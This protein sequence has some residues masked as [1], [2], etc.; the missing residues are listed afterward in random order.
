MIFRRYSTRAYTEAREKVG[1]VNADLQE[2]VAGLR[3]SQA[4]GRQEVNA[5]G[6]AARSEDYR[7]SRM[8]AQ[9]AISIYFPFVALLSEL[10]AAVVLGSAR[11]VVAGALTV[12]T[13]LAFILYLDYF[14][15][16]IQ[17]LSQIFDA[18]QQA[19]VGLRRIG[20]L[21]DTPTSTPAADHPV[22]VRPLSGEVVADGVGFCYSHGRRRRG[23][24]R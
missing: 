3:V 20:D 24:P 19:Q 17:Q 11:R 15:T 1:I 13:L 16:P 12:G 23:R 5:D 8:R 9:T 21:L 18:Y 22:P 6:F 4:L 7:R 14:F 10:A 2:N